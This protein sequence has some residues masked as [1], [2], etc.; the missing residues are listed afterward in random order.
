VGVVK[1]KTL[2]CS[3]LYCISIESLKYP[4]SSFQ[5]L[6]CGVGQS[7][8]VAEGEGGVIISLS[9]RL[10]ATRILQVASYGL[11]FGKVELLRK[12]KR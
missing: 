2:C 1:W 12:R 7:V 6:A 9:K 10:L 5:A 4:S 11:E 3:S 8:V